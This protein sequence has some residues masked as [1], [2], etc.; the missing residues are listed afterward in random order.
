MNCGVCSA[1][2]RKKD[3]CPGCRFDG[4][5]KP[6]YCI[7]CKIRNCAVLKKAKKKFCSRLC[8][9]FPCPTLAHLDK[10]Y[11]TKYCM[12][13]VEN[14]GNIENLGI[15]KF[16]KSEKSRWACKKCGGTMCVHT[17]R[18]C[19]CEGPVKLRPRP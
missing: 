10:R 6:P 3:R 17:G 12:S 11:R 15:R 13:M 8:K 18:C 5:T 4:P 2:L 14:L 9:Q 16:I 7:R 1:Y 19:A